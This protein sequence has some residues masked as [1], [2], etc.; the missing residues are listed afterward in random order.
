MRTHAT[1]AEARVALGE[2]ARPRRGVRA[3]GGAG[4]D[5][6]RRRRSRRPGA[7]GDHRRARR[8]GCRRCPARGKRRCASPG[9]GGAVLVGPNCLGVAD[10]GAGLQL[11]HA[12][13]PAGEV[14]VLS[15][16]GNLVLDLAAL[17]R[18][19]G[20]GV[21]RFVS[22]GNQ[23][24]LT[25]VDLMRPASTTPARGRWRSTPRTWWTGAAF[26]AAARALARA[27]KPVV[28]LAP[29]TIRRRR[30]E[31]RLPHRVDDERLPGGRRGLRCRGRA[32]GGQPDPDG[33]PA[34]GPARRPPDARPTRRRAH[35]R[36]R[37]RGDRRRRAGA[38]DLE[39]PVL[40]RGHAHPLRALLCDRAHA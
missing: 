14:A 30:P 13:L 40:G 1:L 29:G 12:V 10:T 18:E 37:S 11:S 26:V 28:L 19:R 25:V 24:D 22:V 31:C 21:S 4:P 34:R 9:A 35:R 15:Q 6:A 16:S 5:G 38:A 7:R 8:A 39:T 3:R 17:L 23:A 36:R 27:G 20:L 32:P 2:P 33:R